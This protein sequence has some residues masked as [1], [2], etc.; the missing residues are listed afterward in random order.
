MS[1]KG[2]VAFIVGVLLL[3]FLYGWWERRKGGEDSGRYQEVI[4]QLQ[5]D[6]R[7]LAALSRSVDTV[8]VR[9]TVTFSKWLERYHVVT[10]TIHD[11]LTVRERVI[12]A[13]A[14]S[15]I[16]A[17]QQVVSTCEQRVAVRDSMLANLASLRAAD[18]KAFDARL[19]LSNPR[20]LPYAEALVDP[21]QTSTAAFRGGLEIRAFGPLRLVGALEYHT[22]SSSIAPLV[23]ARVTF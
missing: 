18:R 23:G 7:R 20:V 1:V 17:C 16:M 3:A 9:D 13:A 21:F 11:T 4:R 2:V 6:N 5:A 10:D 12:V 22:K 19:R 15:T 14:D 8:Y